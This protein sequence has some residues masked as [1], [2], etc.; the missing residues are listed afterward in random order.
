MFESIQK[1]EEPRLDTV[2]NGTLRPTIGDSQDWYNAGNNNKL[3][4]IGNTVTMEEAS[5]DTD[6]CSRHASGVAALMKNL[7]HSLD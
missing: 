4:N 6:D 2:R 7:Q 1:Q 3:Q 5:H